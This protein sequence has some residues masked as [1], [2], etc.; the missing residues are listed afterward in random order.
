MIKRDSI[1]YKILLGF[2]IV[3]LATVIIFE[4]VFIYGI[5][6]YYYSNIEQLLTDKLQTALDIYDT[7]LGYESLDYKAKFILENDT[8]PDYVEAQVISINGVIIETTAHYK[9][10]HPIAS[11]DFTHALDG[12]ISTWQGINPDTG[13]SVFAVSAPLFKSGKVNGVLRY[14]TSIADVKETIARFLLYSIIFGI[15]VLIIVLY[16]GTIISDS[17]IA[18]IYELK[19]VADNIA[20]G[21]MK[22][23]AKVYNSD[24]IGELAETINYMADEINKTELIKHEFISSISH[25]LRTPLTAIKGWSETILT[26]DIKNIE[27]TTLGLEIISKESERLSG[28]VENLLDFSKLEAEHITIV[29]ENFDLIELIEK[30]LAQFYIALKSNAISSEIN[31]KEKKI[32]IN[33]DRNRIKQVLIN[34]IDNAIKHSPPNSKIICEAE[35]AN[36]GVFIKIIDS[37]E[38]IPEVHLKYITERF[39]KAKMTSSGSGLGLAIAKRIVELHD[40]ELILNSVFGKGTT[41]EIFLPT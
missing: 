26:G 17:I 12:E 39:Y 2:M 31:S 19:L 25:E 32:I 5:N 16:L 30:V 13:E 6:R 40:G 33:G 38:G 21:N 37:G 20:I 22:A 14:I 8:I 11:D 29:K 9:D 15:A 36:N 27:E 28:L 24:E 41:V 10:S 18:P 7:Y 34:I 1:K 4:G 35:S 3:I 23:R